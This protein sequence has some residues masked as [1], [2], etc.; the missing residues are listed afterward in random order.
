MRTGRDE[1]RA[2]AVATTMGSSDEDEAQEAEDPPPAT[3]R[4][5]KFRVVSFMASAFKDPDAGKRETYLALVATFSIFDV[6]VVMGVDSSDPRWKDHAVTFRDLLAHFQ[7]PGTP[8]GAWRIH[9]AVASS[10]RTCLFFTNPRCEVVSFADA[11]PA[12][13]SES[14]SAYAHGLSLWLR[15]PHF[16]GRDFYVSCID[17]GAAR[18]TACGDLPQPRRAYLERLA[19]VHG[20]LLG[21]RRTHLVIGDVGDEEE[22]A[23]A[24]YP[25]FWS[26]RLISHERDEN[27][28]VDRASQRDL[29]VRAE[30]IETFISTTGAVQTPDQAAADHRP[31]SIAFEPGSADDEGIADALGRAKISK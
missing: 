25:G 15:S 29:V 7:P 12:V 31:L 26:D 27:A 14:P 19:E 6:V 30:R 9:A 2:R 23:R 22:A 17:A 10:E 13:A 11:A 28:L 5:P 8:A 1:Q 21:E 3:K 24:S 16:P 18:E 20:P 4:P